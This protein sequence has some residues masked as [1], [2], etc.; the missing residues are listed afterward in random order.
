MGRSTVT[1]ASR[2]PKRESVTFPPWT[3]GI[4]HEGIPG[5]RHGTEFSWDILRDTL[6]HTLYMYTWTV[7]P[8]K[9]MVILFQKL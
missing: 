2:G 7:D 8:I 5:N 1:C 6:V 9:H 3:P 4:I